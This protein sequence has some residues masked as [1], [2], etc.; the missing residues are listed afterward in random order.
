VDE[1]K[2]D[3]EDKVNYAVGYSPPAAATNTTETEEE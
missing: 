1:L 3:Y 2:A